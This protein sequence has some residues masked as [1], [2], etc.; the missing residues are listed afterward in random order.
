MLGRFHRKLSRVMCDAIDGARE[1]RSDS[2]KSRPLSSGRTALVG[3]PGRRSGRPPDLSR[4][5]SLANECRHSGDRNQRQYFLPE[6]NLSARLGACRYGSYDQRKGETVELVDWITG[7]VAVAGL[8][9]GIINFLAD[10][11]RVSETTK[12]ETE[13]DEFERSA[14]EVAADFQRRLVEIEET[15]HGWEQQE[16]TDE[17]VRRQRFDQEALTA[18]MKVR[19]AYRDSAQTWARILATNGGP[20]EA[21]DVVLDVYAERNGQTID[22]GPVSGEDHRTADQ[23]PPNE[24]VYVGVVFSLGSPLPADLR[25]RLSWVDGRGPQK[26][27]GQVP[28]NST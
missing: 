27:E 6:S 17:E 1:E 15:R 21:N 4:V 11:T 23:L 2:V 3:V 10:R 8:G 14:N 13:R 28:V 25:Y 16:R 9:L 19:F 26:D 7:A 22:V 5:D 18:E 12:R 20:A 24:S